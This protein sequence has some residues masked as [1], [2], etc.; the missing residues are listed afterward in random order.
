MR[1]GDASRMS[2]SHVIP[3]TTRRVPRT[4]GRADT[5]GALDVEHR[6]ARQP[7]AS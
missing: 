5:G 6:H 7:G 2:S 3:F 4:A 1:I